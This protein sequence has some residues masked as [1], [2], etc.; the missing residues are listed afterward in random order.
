MQPAPLPPHDTINKQSR[1]QSVFATKKAHLV[2]DTSTPGAGTSSI[3][4]EDITLGSK[5]TEIFYWPYGY[6]LHLPFS[7]GHVGGDDLMEV[8]MDGNDQT[9][10]VPFRIWRHRTH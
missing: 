8:E 3:D 9:V 4:P 5:K 6:W 1:S 7:S 2:M 10:S